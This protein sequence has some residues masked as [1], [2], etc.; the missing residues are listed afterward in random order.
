[1]L[2]AICQ[3]LPGFHG[4]NINATAVYRAC[5]EA[6]PLAPD[7]IAATTFRRHVKS[8]G[9]LKPDADAAGSKARLA[10][11]KAHANEMWQADTLHG[12]YLKLAGQCQPVK[13]FLICFIDDASRVVPHGQFYAADSTP[14][15]IDCFQT[16]LFKR[17][18]PDSIY[19]D[20][21][22][23][24]ASKEFALVANRLGSL[25]LHAPVRDGA[26]KGKI[27]R[28]FRTVRDQFL[29]RDLAAVSALK[30]LNAE[31][32]DWVENTYHVREHS[33]L[34]MKPI[35]R[36]GLDLASLRYLRPS[37][38]N[39]E[40]F[41]LE[42]SR[43]VR[44]DMI[45]SYFGIASNPFATD[46][47][48]PL[49]EAQQR[50]LDILKVHHQQGG[51][52]VLPGEPGTGKS[53]LKQ[54]I[55]TAES[56]RGVTPVINR[57]LH[58]W[59]NMLRLLCQA[60]KLETDGSDHKCEARLIAQAR[61]LNR[62]DKLIIPIIDD[63]HLVPIEALR[64]LRLLLEDFPKNHNLL[65]FG[66]PSFN[67]T[68][69]LQVNEDIRTRITYSAT[70]PRL[71]PDTIVDFINEQLDRVGLSHSTFTE[72]AGALI[73]RSSE[74]VLR[75]IKN[76]SVGA[77]IEAVRDQTKTVDIKQVNAVLL[78]P[79]WRQRRSDEPSEKLC[80]IPS[81]KEVGKSTDKTKHFGETEA[82]TAAKQLAEG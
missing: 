64:K 62:K 14:N 22:S 39:R 10:F 52:C 47:D 67:T 56:K 23:N 34:G 1:M 5:I 75:S 63:A 18:V 71:A 37:P 33:T 6:G 50:H 27:E 28:F 60:F 46:R 53:M 15:L 4:K 59:H 68:L 48:T 3:V 41:Y 42:A 54:A 31:F 66:Q 43:K 25:L 40:L 11:A 76:L 8:F 16:A 57:S 77:L 21:G 17:G 79:H 35:D 58:T 19:V 7:Q 49:L 38:L 13:T 32:V 82:S 2:E 70:L 29:V 55:V 78:Q 73:A 12:P 44:A 51:L 9:L 81:S 61:A 30:Q 26:A 36:F 74:G 24:Y 65:L 69:Q 72:A 20:N 45:R 80:Y